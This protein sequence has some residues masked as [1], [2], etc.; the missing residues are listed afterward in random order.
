MDARAVDAL[1]A[2][3]EVEIHDPERFFRLLFHS[4]EELER[5]PDRVTL[6]AFVDRFRAEEDSEGFG[7]PA[8][9]FV[10]HI[11]YADDGIEV[12]RAVFH[13]R[14][15]DLVETFT[16]MVGGR[17]E[18]D[19][20][21]WRT[22]LTEYSTFWNGHIETWGAFVE[23]FLYHAEDW[24]VTAPAIE[25]VELASAFDDA[26]G[27]MDVFRG[28]GVEIEVAPTEEVDE[29]DEEAWIT[30]LLDLAPYWNGRDETW[31]E[32]TAYFLYHA[33]RLGSRPLMDRATGLVYAASS[34]DDADGR[35]G[36]FASYG[37]TI[38]RDGDPGD[39]Y[40]FLAEYGG[41][42]DGLEAH[43]DD[44]RKWFLHWARE[45]GV[46]KPATLFMDEAERQGELK[47]E[48]FRTYLVELSPVAPEFVPVAV[49]EAVDGLPGLAPEDAALYADTFA[50]LAG[51][52]P[53]V[54]RMTPLE[55]RQLIED[56]SRL[57]AV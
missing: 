9:R 5:L 4:Y 30:F 43:W 40:D 23:F 57:E 37:V 15:D 38:E 44:F 11:E 7:V 55:I 17:Q 33:E 18:Y 16:A 28:Y 34:M 52:M 13:E 1:H 48:F 35:I 36:V 25:L 56:V 14:L 42:W 49:A 19:D 27:K 26:A 10:Q 3:A 22:F 29:D 21:T 2:I 6:Q 47:G 32:F 39:F 51:R 20:G 53:A 46:G 8:E 50:E 45:Q 12:V 24:N 54:T 41:A 31:D